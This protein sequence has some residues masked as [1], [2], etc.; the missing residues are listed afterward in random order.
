[1][2]TPNDDNL[3]RDGDGQAEALDRLLDEMLAGRHHPPTDLDPIFV[4]DVLTIHDLGRQDGAER[5]DR[6]AE[7]RTWR[8]LLRAQ[9]S[10][11]L[12]AVPDTTLPASAVRWETVRANGD[13]VRQSRRRTMRRTSG[14]LGVVSTVM[15]VALLVLAGT[16]IY[17]ARPQ[18]T[19]EPTQLPAAFVPT[20]TAVVS[21]PTPDRAP[22]MDYIHPPSDVI[23]PTLGDCDRPPRTMDK[24]VRML[25]DTVNESVSTGKPIDVPPVLVP[26]DMITVGGMHVDQALP[27]GEAVDTTT[28][29]QL[30]DLYGRFYGCGGIPS[31]NLND[32]PEWAYVSDDGIRRAVFNDNPTGSNLF[33]LVYAFAPRTGTDMR[34]VGDPSWDELWGFRTLADGRIAAY[35]SP[36]PDGLT[37][38]DRERLK[39]NDSPP[40]YVV[41]VRQSGQWFIDEL[42][43]A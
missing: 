11:H 22:R 43:L 35:V 10:P 7:T 16:A 30:A 29:R 20:A 4:H 3:R 1:M 12:R 41:F 13:R 18:G 5:R 28:R 27:D 21:T 34:S 25:N 24:M 36:A 2:T 8:Q 26:W 14:P 31:D 33:W 15:L 19:R 42:P 17:L 9:Q 32:Y 40:Q 6:R 37:D 39:E 23:Q 38:G